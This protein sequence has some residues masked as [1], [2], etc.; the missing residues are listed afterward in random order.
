MDAGAVTGFAALFGSL[1]GAAASITTTWITQRTQFARSQME[2]RLRERQSLYGQFIAEASRLT[3]EAFSHSLEQPET[4]VKLYGLLGRIRLFAAH[5]VLA[6]AEVCV[7]EITEIFAKPNMTI[8]QIRTA[9]EREHFDP[10]REFS[11][12]CRAELREISDGF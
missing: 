3:V 10:V 4:F 5:S 1:M 6:A 12:V 11:R 2:L 9:F 8:D 7:R